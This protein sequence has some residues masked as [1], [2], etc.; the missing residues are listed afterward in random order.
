MEKVFVYNSVSAEVLTIFGLYFYSFMAVILLGLIGPLSVEKKLKLVNGFYW[1]LVVNGSIFLFLEGFRAL[2]CS[3]LI[4][5]A[6]VVIGVLQRRAGLNFFKLNPINNICF[7]S[8]IV[9]FAALILK[10]K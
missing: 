2:F 3:S 8:G 1:S 6:T 10:Y 7:W 9:S 4:M 5:L